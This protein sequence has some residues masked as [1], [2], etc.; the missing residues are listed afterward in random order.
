[1]VVSPTRKLPCWGQA[2]ERKEKRD[3]LGTIIIKHENEAVNVVQQQMEATNR[4]NYKEKSKKKFENLPLI[5]VKAGE[6]YKWRKVQAS[7][8]RFWSIFSC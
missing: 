5:D 4:S 2:A 6:H 8:K 3:D 7:P 1:M